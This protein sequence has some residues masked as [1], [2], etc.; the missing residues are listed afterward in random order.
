MGQRIERSVLT[1][2]KPPFKEWQIASFHLSVHTAAWNIICLL[3]KQLFIALR[4]ISHW[5]RKQCTVFYSFAK[6]LES[7]SVAKV[8]KNLH[9]HSN[10]WFFNLNQLKSEQYR[11]FLEPADNKQLVLSKVTGF[12]NLALCLQAL[13][14]VNVHCLGPGHSKLLKQVAY[15]IFTFIHLHTQPGS[16]T[17]AGSFQKKE[18]RLQRGHLCVYHL[19]H[20]TWGKH[21]GGTTVS[22]SQSTSHW[23]EH[24]HMT[25]GTASLS[26][27]WL[28]VVP[29]KTR[30][31]SGKQSLDPS[32]RFP[33]LNFSPN[34]SR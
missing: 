8:M 1:C 28:L 29:K 20:E 15:D 19:E 30:K 31:G 11:Q 12:R 3:K 21:V 34:S 22:T 16:A 23:Q 7:F 5:K 26:E 9:P 24:S 32:Q 4:I 10:Y 18:Q 17:Q 33:R 6:H 13:S 27:K 25:K 2:L 14:C